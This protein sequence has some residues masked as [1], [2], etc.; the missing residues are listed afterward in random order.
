MTLRQRISQMPWKEFMIGEGLLSLGTGFVLLCLALNSTDIVYNF[1]HNLD[2]VQ[3]KNLLLFG[4]EIV[5][6]VGFL[7]IG[8]PFI[9]FSFQLLSTQKSG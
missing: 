3:V 7:L 2:Q 9:F 6:S 5:L 1:I 4:G 8:F